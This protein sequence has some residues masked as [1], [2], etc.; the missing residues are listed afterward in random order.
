MPEFSHGLDPKHAFPSWTLYGRSAPESGRRRYGHDVPIPDIAQ[1]TAIVMGLL[2][3]MRRASRERLLKSGGIG[4][5]AGQA[6][7]VFLAAEVADEGKEGWGEEET[8]EGDAQHPEQH[9]R[10]Q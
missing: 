10:T 5:D 2:A 9:G 4:A 1:A 6:P 3:S 8:K 7:F